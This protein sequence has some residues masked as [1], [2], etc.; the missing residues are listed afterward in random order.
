M[1]S[2]C[3]MYNGC[4]VQFHHLTDGFDESDIYQYTTLIV[5]VKFHSAI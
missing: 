5:N 3:C 1:P 4:F 2:I